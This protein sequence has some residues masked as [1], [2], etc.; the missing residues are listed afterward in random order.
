MRKVGILLTIVI[1]V[2]AAALPTGKTESQTKSE[3]LGLAILMADLALSGQALNQC[4]RD[5]N[6]TLAT[7]KAMFRRI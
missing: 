1:I 5:L 2:L 4:A 6:D 3:R 7:P